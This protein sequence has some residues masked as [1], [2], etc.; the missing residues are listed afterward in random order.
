MDFTLPMSFALSLPLPRLVLLETPTGQ[1]RHGSELEPGLGTGPGTR[2]TSLS[3]LV[4]RYR[5]PGYYSSSIVNNRDFKLT[6]KRRFRSSGTSQVPTP[7][8]PGF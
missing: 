6:R 3:T 8:K 2:G 7:E 1:E 5:V 4:P